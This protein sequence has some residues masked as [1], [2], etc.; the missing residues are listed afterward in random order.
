[1]GVSKASTIGIIA[2]ASALKDGENLEAGIHYLQEL[3][4]KVKQA[5]N[6][7]LQ[8]ELCHGSFFAGSIEARIE[9]IMQVWSDPEVDILL[10]MRG[11]Y[12]CMQ[13]LD[14]LDYD[15]M[16]KNPKPVL[17]YSDLTALFMALYTQAYHGKLELFHTPMLIELATMN[18]TTNDSFIDL[19][20]QIDP[21]A[22]MNYQM[23][24]N[25]GIKVHGGNLSLVAS[26]VGTKYLPDMQ[27][28]ILFLEDCKEPAYK[29]ERMFYQLELAGIFDSIAEMQLGIASEANYPDTYL[30]E[31]VLRKGFSLAKDIPVGHAKT[32]LS[33]VLG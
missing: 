29:I 8:E 16:G 11:G 18:K 13:L 23:K 6:I 1:M 19:L 9:G 27:D 3:G 12:G 28:A 25:Q 22:Y 26:L 5:K 15:Y 2:P 10:S 21:E 33:L 31:L 32:N 20:N 17:G 7:L 14:K 24:L 4:F 30:S